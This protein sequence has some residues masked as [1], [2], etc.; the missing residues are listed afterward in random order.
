VGSFCLDI[1]EVST[2]DYRECVK[3]HQCTAPSLGPLCNFSAAGHGRHPI[4]C[5]S[6]QQAKSFCEVQGKRLPTVIE[7]HWAATSGEGNSKYPWGDE[8]PSSQVCWS[9]GERDRTEIGTCEGGSHP[10]GA[11]RLGIQD[12]EGN[13]A[14]WAVATEN[15]IVAAGSHFQ[16]KTL[17]PDRFYPAKTPNQNAIG[18]R[19]AT[20]F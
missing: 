11:G 18:I 13:V 17:E 7:M 14:E 3:S 10:G 6:A 19:C 15:K 2:N 4:N 5:V 16:S 12:L 20:G 9:G 1:Y 8:E